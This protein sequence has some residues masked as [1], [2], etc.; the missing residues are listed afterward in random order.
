MCIFFKTRAREIKFM[1]KPIHT[2]YLELKISFFINLQHEKSKESLLIL[3]KV[4]FLKKSKI[5]TPSEIY[6]TERNT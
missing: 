1:R 4:I 3:F 6:I 2:M 5:D